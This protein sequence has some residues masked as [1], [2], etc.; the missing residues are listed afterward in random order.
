MATTVGNLAVYLTARTD[1]Y[2]KGLRKAERLSEL[3]ARR[4][5]AAQKIA[6]GGFVAMG[7]G[8]MAMARRQLK[9]IDSTAKMATRLGATTEGLVKLRHA[10]SIAGVD[11]AQLDKNLEML[12]RR[13]GEAEQGLG[14]ARYALEKLGL[15]SQRLAQMSP[16]QAFVEI[17]GKVSK[18][19]TQA[20]KAAAAN[21]LFGRS[22]VQLL[23]VLELDKRAMAGLMEE[24]EKLGLTF[25]RDM[26]RKVEEANDAL[27]RAQAVLTG[28]SRDMAI[29]LAPSIEKVANGMQFTLLPVINTVVTG[30]EEIG[31]QAGVAV[32]QLERLTRAAKVAKAFKEAGGLGALMQFPLGIPLGGRSPSRP[33]MPS[34]RRL[35]AFER[36]AL[37]VADVS[38]KSIERSPRLFVPR[39]VAAMTK[40]VA[41]RRKAVLGP[42]PQMGAL[43]PGLGFG[44]QAAMAGASMAAMAAAGQPM[45]AGLA[46][47]PEP[48][49]A[50][51]S[52]L[53]ELWKSQQQKAVSG[54]SKEVTLLAQL[55]RSNN[56]IDQKLPAAVVR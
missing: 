19:A 21:Q 5:R 36:R 49:R 52:G 8:L 13:L 26:G 10:A 44:L 25:S 20:E 31:R 42:V 48:A 55:V 18:M 24:A 32:A 17:A 56:S 6:T 46:P 40:A 53:S 4:T 33:K 51:F 35:S 22:G 43:P 41:E 38:A 7:A 54:D 50:A 12:T 47:A 3:W 27:T 2:E 28:V 30:T 15:S 14:E 34:A 16:V 23:N 37:V 1:Q 39:A 45:V 9:V 29:E 11:S